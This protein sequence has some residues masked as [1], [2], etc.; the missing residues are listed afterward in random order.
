M[1][2]SL[3]DRNL[4]E[5]ARAGDRTAIDTLVERLRCIV[6]IITMM[7]ARLPRP[8]PAD[9]VD[10]AAQNALS[11]MWLKLPTYTGDTRLEA[12]AFGFCRVELLGALRARTRRA[13][14]TELPELQAPGGG[15][16]PENYERVRRAL[17]SIDRRRADVIRLRHLDDLKFEEIAVRA[18]M[19]LNTAKTLYYRGVQDVQALLRTTQEWETA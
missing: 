12:W 11:S 5:R 8:L 2:A 14:L 13:R 15:T 6:P 4:A 17:D 7:N 9:D 19:P 3:T 18:S 1:E 16:P 10:E